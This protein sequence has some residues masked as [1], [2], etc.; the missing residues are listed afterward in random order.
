MEIYIYGSQ[1]LVGKTP[2]TGCMA[3]IVAVFLC[4]LLQGIYCFD[5]VIYTVHMDCNFRSDS[6]I[7]SDK[8]LR[9]GAC[10]YMHPRVLRS[11]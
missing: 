7:A 10:N 5:I 9:G 4:I 3:I 8:H 11:V 6:R 1:F 2:D